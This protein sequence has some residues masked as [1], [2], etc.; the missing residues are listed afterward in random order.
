MSKVICN[1]G[2]VNPDCAPRCH[3]CSKIFYSTQTVASDSSVTPNDWV[4]VEAMRI[5]A[6]HSDEECP[7]LHKDLV[8]A[9]RSAYEQG[10][11]DAQKDLVAPTKF[12]IQESYER[13]LE[14]AARMVDGLVGMSDFAAEI[15]ALKKG[16]EG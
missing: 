5:I 7:L 2:G 3:S 4:E 15:R 11:L 12:C 14:V 10:R 1:C 9:L 6:W 13:G 8:L 16:G